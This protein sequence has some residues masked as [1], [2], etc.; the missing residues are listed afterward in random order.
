LAGTGIRQNPEGSGGIQG[1]FR[2]S[3]PAGISA[4]K[5]CDSG[6]NQEFL[7]PP[8]KPHSCEKILRK[9]QEKN[10]ILRN[11]G[12]NSFFGP[13][14]KFLKTGICNLAPNIL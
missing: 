7:R 6:K 8:P 10:E 9:T 12:R 3:C 5:S 4:K 2:N 1:K 14:N 13:K 11:P